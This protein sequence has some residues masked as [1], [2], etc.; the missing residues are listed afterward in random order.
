MF[1]R[2]TSGKHSFRGLLS[3]DPT[4]EQ[5]VHS[6]SP[7]CPPHKMTPSR[8]L[9][10][11][12][13]STLNPLQ[14]WCHGRHHGHEGEAADVGADTANGSKDAAK[15]PEAAQAPLINVD[16]DEEDEDESPAAAVSSKKK[17]MK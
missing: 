6:P 17:E 2:A 15:V 7:T 5:P 14:R 1:V 12:A 3:N 10:A 4:K 16:K 8:T 11:M 9:Q 13:S